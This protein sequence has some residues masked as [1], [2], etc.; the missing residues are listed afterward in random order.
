M[1][2]ENFFVKKIMIDQC[3]SVDILYWNNTRSW[4]C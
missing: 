1:E 2:I 3:S 4:S